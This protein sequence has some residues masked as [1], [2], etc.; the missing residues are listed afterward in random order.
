VNLPLKDSEVSAVGHAEELT[1]IHSALVALR[2]GDSAA[3][4]P[5]QGSAQFSKV[6]DV[7]NDLVEQNVAMA[8]ELSKLSQR[9]SSVRHLKRAYLLR[10]LITLDGKE[11]SCYYLAIYYGLANPRRKKRLLRQLAEVSL[12]VS[13]S[14]IDL[15]GTTRLDRRVRKVK[16][17]RVYRRRLLARLRPATASA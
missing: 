12:P 10:K 5:I 15:T 14:I 11:R 2:R 17:A 8:E 3:K 1:L 16:G 7:F 13:A 9:L 6:S 4:L